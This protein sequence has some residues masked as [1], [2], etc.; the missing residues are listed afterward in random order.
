MTHL[1]ISR[2]FH[3]PLNI[4]SASIQHGMLT[5]VKMTSHRDMPALGIIASHSYSAVCAFLCR[6]YS[7][8]I[9]TPTP[10]GPLPRPGLHHTV[11]GGGLSLATL[12]ALAI[13]KNEPTKALQPSTNM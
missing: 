2:L 11:M 8:G 10:E 12:L 6:E 9:A 4:P 13:L 3:Q 1:T 5:V 7:G